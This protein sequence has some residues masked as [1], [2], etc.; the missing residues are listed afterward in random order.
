VNVKDSKTVRVSRSPN[1]RRTAFFLGAGASAADGVP[2]TAQLNF[3]V[4]AYLAEKGLD[5]ALGRFYVS[6]FGITSQ[7]VFRDAQNWREYLTEGTT[8]PDSS[9]LPDLTETLS[10]LDVC[11]ADNHGLGP[12]RAGIKSGS[13]ECAISDVN[14]EMLRRARSDLVEALRFAIVRAVSRITRRMSATKELVSRMRDHD[15]VVTTNWDYL[16]E[17]QLSIV[18]RRLDGGWLRRQ[19]MRFGCVGEG[20]TNWRGQSLRVQTPQPRTILKLHGGVNW[21]LCERC[22]NLYINVEYMP[23]SLEELTGDDG[24]CHCGAKL[25]GLLVAPSYLKDYQ[26]AHLKSVWLNAQ[27]ALEQSDHWIFVGYSLPA[28]DFHIRA[29]LL[30][31]LCARRSQSRFRRTEITVVTRRQREAIDQQRL[32]ERYQSFF[33]LETPTVHEDGLESYLGAAS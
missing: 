29:L 15:F 5:T 12:E 3:G 16:V 22:Q 27:K 8:L 9:A 25:S 32:V 33:R 24:G 21:Y 14:N 30:R 4:S 10:L 19:S 6:G 18:Q 7:L 31:A 23:S 1:R 2:V 13:K 11:I 20:V 26:N 28:D 17:K